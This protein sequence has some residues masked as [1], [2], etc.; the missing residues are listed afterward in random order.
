VGA[1]DHLDAPPRVRRDAGQ[2]AGDQA[3]LFIAAQEV[4]QD[5]AADVTGGCGHDD[6]RSSLACSIRV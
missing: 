1:L 5:L 4:L 3:E 6:H 2:V